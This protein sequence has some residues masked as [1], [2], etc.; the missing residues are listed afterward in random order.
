MGDPARK[1]GLDDDDA[2]VVDPLEHGE[3]WKQEIDR[4][5]EDV[6]SGCVRMIPIEEVGFRA[7]QE[8]ALGARHTRIPSPRILANGPGA[9][10][11]S[12]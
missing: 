3:E 8:R 1:P 5:I 4:R 11:H 10:G 2:L 7:P 12:L 6:R 9:R